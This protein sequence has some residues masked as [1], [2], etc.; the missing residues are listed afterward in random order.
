MCD[1]HAFHIRGLELERA[2][3]TCLPSYVLYQCRGSWHVSMFVYDFPF[4]QEVITEASEDAA[5]S[6]N[7]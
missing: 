5:S 4:G 6:Q 1:M 3:R 2:I 7:Y